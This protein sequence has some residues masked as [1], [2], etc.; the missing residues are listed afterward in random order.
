LCCTFFLKGCAQRSFTFSC[1][2]VLP[3]F[4]LIVWDDLTIAVAYNYNTFI[5]LIINLIFAAGCVI[6]LLKVDF[7]KWGPRLSRV[8]I[9]L[10][11]NIIIFDLSI[12]HYHWKPIQWIFFYYIFWPVTWLSNLSGHL[13]LGPLSLNISSRIH[14]LIM[15]GII[16]L[17][18]SLIQKVRKLS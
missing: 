6:F 12:F 16:Y 9:S 2:F 17:L 13:E 3:Y 18:I 1:G 8:F 4:D 14:F 7:S 11:V 15:S 10:L 5:S